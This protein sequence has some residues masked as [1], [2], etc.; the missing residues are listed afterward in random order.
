MVLAEMKSLE[1]HQLDDDEE[2]TVTEVEKEGATVTEEVTVNEVEEEVTL[3][4]GGAVVL[5]TFS[6]EGGE[7]SGVVQSTFSGEGG[8]E[9]KEEEKE[10]GEKE[11]GEK[12]EGE[13]EEEEKEEGGGKDDE[14][15]GGGEDDEEEGG[16][17]HVL[18][19][20]N[21]KVVNLRDGR[22]SLQVEA[23]VRYICGWIDSR[24]TNL[25]I[26]NMK[27]VAKQSGDV[28]DDDG[29]DDSESSLESEE[30]VCPSCVC[31]Y[32]SI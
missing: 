3:T 8:E 2:G 27:L 9:E 10:E 23:A 19:L 30:E 15:E 14:E 17:K 28:I 6:G 7:E 20:L 31:F 5:D 29:D 26:P 4:G 12:E 25:K 18:N 21:M 16:R 32:L 13:G 1:I 24:I 11:E 22:Y